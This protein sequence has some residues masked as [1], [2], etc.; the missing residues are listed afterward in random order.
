MKTPILILDEPSLG[1][2]WSGSTTLMERLIA[3]TEGPQSLV[4]ISHDLRLVAHYAKDIAV[5]H[6]G[7]LIKRGP[8]AEILLD[9]ELLMQVGLE[10]LPLTQLSN[11]LSPLG[12]PREAVDV[13]S[14]SHALHQLLV[15]RGL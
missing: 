12:F 11:R 3:H 9:H 14:F 6:G 13:D 4:F 8:S 1:M 15:D 7:S 10:P 2:D 5:L